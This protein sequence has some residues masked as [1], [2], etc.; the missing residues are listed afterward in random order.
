MR[1]VM[2]PTSRREKMGLGQKGHLT[3][4]DG[5]CPKH[6]GAYNYSAETCATRRGCQRVWFQKMSVVSGKF[7]KL[8]LAGDNAPQ[9]R[10]NGVQVDRM[11]GANQVLGG[12]FVL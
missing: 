12:A 1:P 7:G 4:N 6:P 3:P 10:D 2:Q 5:D 9:V 11:T 8:S